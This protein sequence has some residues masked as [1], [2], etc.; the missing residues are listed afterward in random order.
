MPK[1]EFPFPMPNGWF[2]I[3]RCHELDLGKLEKAG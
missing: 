1:Q 2:C 3:L